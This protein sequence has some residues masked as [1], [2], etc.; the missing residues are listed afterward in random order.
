VRGDFEVEATFEFLQMPRPVTGAAA[1]VTLYFFMDDE[2]WNGLWFGKMIDRQR[3][4]VIVTGH[5]IG[6]RE[7]RINNFTDSLA[8]GA[9]PGTVR[10]RVVRQGTSFGLYSAEGE[11]REY[12][13]VHTLEISSEEVPI[14]RF[15]VDPGWD[16]RVT[17][18]V[19]L[20]DFTMTAEEFVG[21][22]PRTR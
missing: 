12:Q 2:E 13:H 15:A 1:G 17:M 9:E 6:K 11:T 4:P 7:E 5:R 16:S 21:Y 10:L 20:L 14:V 8:T 19:R 3:G 18:D 22:E